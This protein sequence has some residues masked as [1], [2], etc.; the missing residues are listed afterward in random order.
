MEKLQSGKYY[1]IYNRGNNKQNI[2]FE[3]DNY[4]YFK[5]LLKKHLLPILKIYAYCLLPNHFHLVL[6]INDDIQKPYQALSNLMNAYT[7]AINKRFNRSGSL[8]QKPFKR[9]EIEN[10]NYFKNLILY[11]HHNPEKHN[12]IDDYRNYEHSS[13]KS[14]IIS[15]KDITDLN[16]VD[17]YFDSTENF[18]FVHNSKKIQFDIESL[19]LED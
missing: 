8:F 4:Q 14:L 12:V 2:Y 6:R 9:I 7:K 17:K 10:E 16:Y 18:I 1:H 5:Q 11:V 13:Y 19:I 3:D 15:K